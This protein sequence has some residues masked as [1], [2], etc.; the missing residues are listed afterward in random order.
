MRV[1]TRHAT[2]ACAT[3]LSRRGLRRCEHSLR[4]VPLVWL[5]AVLSFAEAAAPSYQSAGIVNAATGQPDVAPNTLVTIRGTDLATSTRTLTVEEARIGKLPITLPGTGTMVFID[6]IPA[7]IWLASPEQVNFVIPSQ[8]IPTNRAR[9]VVVVNGMRGPEILLRIVREAPGLFQRDPETAMGTHM[10][11]T[12]IK[13]DS[14]AMP[15]EDI[16]LMATGLGS[17]EPEIR[18]MEVAKV[19]SPLVRRADFRVLVNDIPVDDARIRYV[20]AAMGYSGMYQINL[21]L[22]EDTPPDPEVKVA[23]GELVSQ[24]GARLPV[25]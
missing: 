19:V 16:V 8:V 20:G 17:V 3:V 23:I 15:G 12:P 1:S 9:L 18:Y 25:R 7:P 24:G 14:P 6:R 5:S 21:T 10:D 11:G 22:P 2:S 4:M 13:A